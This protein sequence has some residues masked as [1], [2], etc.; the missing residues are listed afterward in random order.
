M[1]RSSSW[2]I[3]RMSAMFVSRLRWVSGTAF[4]RLSD[5][6]VNSTT[7]V[8]GGVAR[9][10]ALQ[11]R[12][13]FT[14]AVIFST[15]RTEASTSSTNRNVS[16]MAERSMPEAPSFA[17]SARAV[18]TVVTPSVSRE[19]RSARVPAVQFTITG[20]LPANSAASRNTE[21][22]TDAGIMMPT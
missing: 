2:P 1:S 3:F 7:A 16:S 19:C 14:A 11:R 18:T 15:G 4:G 5:P 8:S 21:A 17:S 22:P 12:R 6:L 13:L 10:R 20:V 9:S